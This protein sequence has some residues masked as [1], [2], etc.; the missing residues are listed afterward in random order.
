MT[1]IQKLTYT[2]KPSSAND[3]PTTMVLLVDEEMYDK[4]VKGDKTIPVTEIVDSFE[5]FKFDTPGREGSLGK[6]SKVE[7]Q[8]AFGGLTNEI[9]IAEFMLQHG[10]I[11]GRKAKKGGSGAEGSEQTRLLESMLHA[12][13]RAY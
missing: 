8:M 5:I 9:D 4:Y 3:H 2:P 6:P 7:L 1:V 12:D 11:L 13:R 10:T